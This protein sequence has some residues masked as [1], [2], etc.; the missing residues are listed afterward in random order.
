MSK[1]RLKFHSLKTTLRF[2]EFRCGNCPGEKIWWYCRWF[3][4]VATRSVT[5]MT[6]NMSSTLW[7]SLL[8]GNPLAS[9]S[10]KLLDI[11][12]KPLSCLSTS[13]GFKQGDVNYGSA[14]PTNS[15]RTKAT[16]L[17]VSDGPCMCDSELT[18]EQGHGF[19]AAQTFGRVCSLSSSRMGL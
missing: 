5:L 11:M 6:C 13:R 4:H 19:S 9:L 8:S 1:G 3:R 2:G 14:F 12:M 16:Y 10:N 7:D 17:A 18:M 15:L